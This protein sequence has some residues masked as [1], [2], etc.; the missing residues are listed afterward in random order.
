MKFTYFLVLVVVLCALV[1]SKKK[2][3]F[4]KSQKENPKEK[5]MP[6][7]EQFFKDLIEKNKKRI[8]ELSKLS[9]NIKVDGIGKYELILLSDMQITQAETQLALIKGY[10]E[11]QVEIEKM[12]KK[13]NTIQEQKKA[14]GEIPQVESKPKMK[15]FSKI[16][17]HLKKN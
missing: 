9:D 7:L 11:R 17:K 14:T 12:Q 15:W 13:M 6:E 3:S 1:S 16:L 8:E 5:S 10:N 4:L 2:R